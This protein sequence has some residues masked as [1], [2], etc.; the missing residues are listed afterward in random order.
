LEFN[1]LPGGDIQE[2]DVA[3]EAS[4]AAR[5]KLTKPNRNTPSF[6]QIRWM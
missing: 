2:K 5:S 1:L 4:L 6:K 3:V